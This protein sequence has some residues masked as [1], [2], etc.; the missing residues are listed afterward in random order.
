MTDVLN[1]ISERIDDVP[2]IIEICKQLNLDEM[3]EKHL[4]T[5]GL[6]QGIDNGKLT[7]GW[8]SYIISQA[9]HRMNS[10][11]D[12]A[13]KIPLVLT[14]LLGMPIRN[15]E[16]SDDRLANLLDRF[17]DDTAWEALEASLWKNVVEVYELPMNIIRFDGTAACGYHDITENGLMQYGASKDHRPDL[18]QLKI[19]AA[20]IDPGL[21]IGMD[22]ASGEQNDDVMYVPLIQILKRIACKGYWKCIMRSKLM[23]KKID[24]LF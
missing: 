22:I 1:V 20:S 14:S 15:V 24:M 2:L 23:V 4:G 12:W 3:I 9:D 21:V 13:N 16:F 6:Q 11:R 10:V 7:I 19:M 17:A 5:H 18:P 8:L